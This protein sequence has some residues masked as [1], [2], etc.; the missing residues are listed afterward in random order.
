MIPNPNDFK[1]KI[2]NE[3]RK[4]FETGL[5][6]SKYLY[7]TVVERPLEVDDFKVIIDD[8]NEL[9]ST[10]A[11]KFFARIYL[12]LT[13]REQK[14][15][16]SEAVKRHEEIHDKIEEIFNEFENMV[17]EE[18]EKIET[19]ET[20]EQLLDV[21]I[22]AI[23]RFLNIARKAIY[24]RIEN[25]PAALYK[26]IH[27]AIFKDDFDVSFLAPLILKE[28]MKKQDVIAT[29]LAEDNSLDS[30]NVQLVNAMMA[31]DVKSLALLQKAIEKKMDS[32]G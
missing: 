30:L 11:M 12:A 7:S 19:C 17:D 28:H 24:E 1:E 9:A 4:A 31:G 13:Q 21:G 10:V 27:L 18:I 5:L 2:L 6:K 25:M 26:K 22:Q 32:G 16:L 20:E 3:Y 23:G 14:K 8:N 15:L 29:K